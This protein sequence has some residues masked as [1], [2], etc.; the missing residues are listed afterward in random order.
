M[1]LLAKELPVKEQA[2]IGERDFKGGITW[3][4]WDKNLDS[5]VANDEIVG[6]A[7]TDQKLWSLSTTEF[8]ELNQ[9]TRT[10]DAAIGDNYFW[11]LR[12]P[13]EG[14]DISSSTV[15]F[16]DYASDTIAFSGVNSPNEYIRPAL[17]F[18]LQDVLFMSGNKKTATVDGKLAEASA[19]EGTT[20]FTIKDSSMRLTVNS[21]TKSGS[22]LYISFSNA[23]TG[24]KNYVSC[25]LTSKSTGDVVYYGKLA[26]CSKKGSGTAAIPLDSVA[27]GSYTLQFFAEEANE[28]LYSDFCSIPVTVDLT[29]DGE[30][31]TV[32]K[33]PLIHEH[34]YSGWTMNSTH[35][36]KE[37]IAE[38]CPLSDDN[39]LKDSYGEHI[40]DQKIAEEKYIAKIMINRKIRVFHWLF[41]VVCC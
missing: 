28:A 24:A 15:R 27:D 3:S 5:L 21:I 18:K 38:N 17:S 19:L 11:W 22:K 14:G 23:S 33:S 37:C 8:K 32:S 26:D 9:K 6:P 40:Y 35:H 25:I 34:S 29:M 31:G 13:A 10:Y 41:C 12:S 1:E 7:V 30:N 16:R 2:L 39:S 20:K 4:D 36:W